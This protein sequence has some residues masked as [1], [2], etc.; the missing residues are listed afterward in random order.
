MN[1]TSFLSDFPNNAKHMV[2]GITMAYVITSVAFLAYAMLVTYTN[3][4]EENL[5]MIV[6]VTTL[7]AV[8]VA[9][10][11]AARGANSRGFLWGMAAGLF[12]IVILV[13][14][15][16]VMLPTFT[17]DTRTLTTAVI[18]VAGGGLGGMLGIN[19]KK[20]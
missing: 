11:D 1:K 9:G 5:P 7:L 4:S 6:A 16:I 10:F 17:M 8:L 15:M 20:S 12:Y 18:G 3:M 13:L 19:F 14:I 2:I